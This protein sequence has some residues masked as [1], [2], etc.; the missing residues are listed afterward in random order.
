MSNLIPRMSAAAGKQIASV[1]NDEDT[2]T[3]RAADG[4]ELTMRLG[5]YTGMDGVIEAVAQHWGQQ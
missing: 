4:E 5:D 3:V 2:I 1:E